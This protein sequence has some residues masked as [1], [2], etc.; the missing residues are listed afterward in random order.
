[1]ISLATQQSEFCC[2]ANAGT[3]RCCRLGRVVGGLSET[4][5]EGQ[6]STEV[7]K[8]VPPV[9]EKR[10]ARDQPCTRAIGKAGEPRLQLCW[11]QGERRFAGLPWQRAG[12]GC[13]RAGGFRDLEAVWWTC[14]FERAVEPGPSCRIDNFGPTAAARTGGEDLQAG[15][16]A[17]IRPKS[18]E[19]MAEQVRA[20]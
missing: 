3:Q 5:A 16:S 11:A 7:E 17:C 1:M 13:R 18:A 20:V 10:G 8:E 4:S 6:G 9:P 15:K 2:R 12:L 14:D 19:T